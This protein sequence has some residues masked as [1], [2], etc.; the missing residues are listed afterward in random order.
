MDDQLFIRFL[1]HTNSPEDI[2]EIDR[3]IA[4]EKVNAD[5]LFEMERIWMLKDELRFSDEQGICRSY[6]QFLT[7]KTSNLAPH[8][9]KRRNRLFTGMKYGA[10]AVVL[11]L[12]LF[13]IYRLQ[14]REDISAINMIETPKGE[15]ASVTLSDGTKVWLNAETKLTYPAQFGRKK[16]EVTIEGEGYFEVAKNDRKPFVLNGKGFNIHVLGTQFNVDAHPG[17]DVSIALKEGKISVEVAEGENQLELCASDQLRLMAGGRTIL[18]KI[19]V[20]TINSWTKGEFIFVAQPLA[21]IL[22]SLER[23][24]NVQIILSDESLSREL[25]NC[26]AK[27]GTSLLDILELLRKTKKVNYRFDNDSII[28]TKN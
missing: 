2:K 28:I 25:F 21:A 4:Q 22:R 8:P 12:L 9:Q 1:T 19:D 23:S 14:Y 26:R 10:A 6:N 5:S 17:E 18:Q 3:W 15:K 24:F 7:R 20:E 16:R 11:L 27:A 13:N